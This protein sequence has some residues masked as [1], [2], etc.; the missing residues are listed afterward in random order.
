MPHLKHDNP[1]GQLLDWQTVSPL[2]PL[3][4]R[5]DELHIWCIKLKLEEHQKETAFRLLSDIQRDK[6][7]R[8]TTTQLKDAY[9]ASRYYLLKLLAG[10]SSIKAEQV[11]LA[12]SRLNKP[13]LEPNP[14]DVEFNFTDTSYQGESTG[15]FAFTNRRPVGVDIEALS[16]GANF[17]AIAA[18]RFSSAEIAYAS[19]ELGSIDPHRFLSIWTRKEAYG[20]ATGKGIN[21][22]MRDVDLATNDKFVLDFHDDHAMTK[23]YRLHQIRINQQLVAS[24][25]HEGHQPLAIKAFRSTNHFP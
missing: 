6:Y 14:N 25:V 5:N 13:Y 21:F 19:D 3:R 11:R 10:Y 1:L 2:S 8:R 4:L 15:L 16:R 24:V 7:Q 18:K 12:Y 9:L 20:K 22:K 23:E 17:S